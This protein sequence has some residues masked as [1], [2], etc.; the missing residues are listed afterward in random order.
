V[1][2]GFAWALLVVLAFDANIPPTPTWHSTQDECK[3][4]AA[5]RVFQ[6]ETTNQPVAYVECRRVRITN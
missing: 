4:Y 2:P 5:V 1:I 3:R 6:Y